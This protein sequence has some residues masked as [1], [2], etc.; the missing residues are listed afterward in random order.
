MIKSDCNIVYK[1]PC[2]TPNMFA[3]AAVY[4]HLH[5]SFRI[6]ATLEKRKN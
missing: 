5:N 4:K 3:K 1:R 2:Q 6:L